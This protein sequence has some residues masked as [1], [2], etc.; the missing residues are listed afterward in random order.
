MSNIKGTK[1]EKNL[2]EVFAINDNEERATMYDRMARDAHEEGFDSI[3]ALLE[4]LK[5][6]ENKHDVCFSDLRVSA[7]DCGCST[8]NN[9]NPWFCSN[10]GHMV[11]NKNIVRGCTFICTPID[12]N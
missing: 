2:I 3:A 12:D 10:C 11:N 4:Q 5:E 7:E 1:T 9:E 8:K 6:V